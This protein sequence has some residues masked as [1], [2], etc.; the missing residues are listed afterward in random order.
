MKRLTNRALQ[1]GSERG[2]LRDEGSHHSTDS[3]PR[4]VSAVLAVVI[5]VVVEVIIVELPLAVQ[6]APTRRR[7]SI[8]R[9]SISIALGD[10]FSQTEIKFDCRARLI[11]VDLPK[12]P[13]VA[14]DHTSVCGR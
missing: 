11:E 2:K 7:L 1:I 8:I 3:A 6:R 13:V 5:E 14:L 9:A 10:I 12:S 4:S